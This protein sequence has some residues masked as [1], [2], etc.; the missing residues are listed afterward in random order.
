[1][2]LVHFLMN[3]SRETVTI[4]L[5]NGTILHG[6][7]TGVDIA[8]NT[9]LRAVKMTMKDGQTVQL[10]VM[11]VRG[12]NIRYFI[13]PDTPKMVPP[14]HADVDVD[15]DVDVEEVGDSVDVELAENDKLSETSSRERDIV[16]NC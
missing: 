7:V 14:G 11:S 2:K 12:N 3:L 9:H 6:T 16:H 15:V 10:D 1:M 8:M 5:K 4:E 13:L